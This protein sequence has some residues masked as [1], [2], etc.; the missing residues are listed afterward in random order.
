MER[1]TV[2]DAVNKCYKLK[3]DMI[4]RSIIQELGIYEDIMA[5]DIEKA[6]NIQDI[7]NVYIKKGVKLNPYWE[8]IGK[9]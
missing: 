7:R 5:Q 9:E 2:Y 3:P 4:G 6:G 8:K 1:M